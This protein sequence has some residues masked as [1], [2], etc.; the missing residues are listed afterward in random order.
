M[1]PF[2]MNVVELEGKKILV[3]TDQAGSTK[4]KDV[5]VSDELRRRMIKPHSPKVDTWKENVRCKPVRKV[6]PTSTMLIEK[7]VR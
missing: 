3:R 4:G 5:G 7:Y 1:D 6:K 2:P